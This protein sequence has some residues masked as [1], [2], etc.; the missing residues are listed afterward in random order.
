MDQQFDLFSISEMGVLYQLKRTKDHIKRQ[1]KP[2]FP[3]F[4]FNDIIKPISQFHFWP[5]LKE[6]KAG[7]SPPPIN[8]RH[9]H[10]PRYHPQGYIPVFHSDGLTDR[11]SVV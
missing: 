6:G 8:L 11:K 5:S 10:R 9:H 7:K 1:V 4:V 3:A 2:D